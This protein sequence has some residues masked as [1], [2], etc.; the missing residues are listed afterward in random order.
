MTVMIQI[1]SE[2]TGHTIETRPGG[3]EPARYSAARRSVL[4]PVV[5][6]I[7]FLGSAFS[8]ALGQEAPT[9]PEY[10][11]SAICS[12]CHEAE[13][14][15]W[16]QSHHALAWT[17]PTRD[18]I[19]GDFGNASFVHRGVTHRF[20]SEG[21]DF[22]IEREAEGMAERFP[23]VGVAG[24]APLQQYIVETEPG[25]LQSHDVV[26]DVEKQKWYHL[27]PAQDLAPGNG[28]HWTGPYKSWNARCA[29]C[30]ATG[31]EKGYDT[32]ARQ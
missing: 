5:L 22:F 14:N 3:A 26:W 16:A 9:V 21:E 24:V 13:A 25:R 17:E 23:V 18:N 6:A 29:E 10:V 11:G 28:L 32:A 12:D 15:A 4:R 2:S 19:L 1:A 7:T 8:P 27:Y 30:H 31:Y 20:L